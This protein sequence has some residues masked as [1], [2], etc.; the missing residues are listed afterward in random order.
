MAFRRLC[1]PKFPLPNLT[2]LH[3]PL[4]FISHRWV[5]SHLFSVIIMSRHI[6]FVI[7]PSRGRRMLFVVH[8]FY[9]S[10]TRFVIPPQIPLE[11]V[12]QAL[13]HK[14][15]IKNMSVS[16]FNYIPKNQ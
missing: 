1:I 2:A 12:D 15:L 7:S 6:T 9:I 8:I 10:R 11:K 13:S 5:L 14:N 3:S 16:S 4:F